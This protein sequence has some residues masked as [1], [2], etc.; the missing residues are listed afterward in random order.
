MIGLT[1]APGHE[2]PSAPHN[3]LAACQVNILRECRVRLDGIA[4]SL[5]DGSIGR[6]TL[7]GCPRLL[8]AGLAAVVLGKRCHRTRPLRVVRLEIALVD[9]PATP[10]KDIAVIGLYRVLLDTVYCSDLPVRV[11]PGS[12]LSGNNLQ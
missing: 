4:G 5:V 1:Q 7:P 3:A 6:V 12:A 9:A 11:D 8:V 10:R 2:P